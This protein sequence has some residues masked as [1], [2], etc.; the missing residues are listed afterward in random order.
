MTVKVQYNPSTLKVSYN[1]ATNKV[2]V[3]NPYSANDCS[4]FDAGKTPLEVRAVFSGVQLCP[5]KSWP[6]NV[7]LNTTWILTQTFSSACGWCLWEYDDG[8][9]SIKLC[10]NS[11][12]NY[13]NLLAE[14]ARPGLLRY[15]DSYNYVDF[16]HNI[17]YYFYTK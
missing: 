5:G 3:S 2:Q 8:N 7:N 17:P 11:G 4:C 10:G 13:S 9:W 15:F 16:C 14:D 6:D 1:S 12:G